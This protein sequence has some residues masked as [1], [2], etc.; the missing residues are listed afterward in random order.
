MSVSHRESE[1]RPGPAL[2]ISRTSQVVALIRAEL[3]RP[4]TVE[5][6]PDAQRKLCAGMEPTRGVRLRSAI[7]ARTRFFDERVL[8]EISAGLCQV[9]I[10]GAGYDDRALRFRTAGV[11]FFELDH[12]STQSDK[13][14]RLKRIEADV[15][16]LR[17]IPVDF[18]SDPVADLLRAQGLHPEEPSLFICEGLLVY[19]DLQACL[20]LLVALRSLAAPSSVLATSFT[21]IREGEVAE[22]AIA[23]AN[24]RR[25]S[26]WTEPWRTVLAPD[27]CVA[28][29]AQAGWKVELGHG[30][31]EAGRGESLGHMLLLTAR[32]C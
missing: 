15:R 6:D 21:T 32:P 24:A 2:D 23:K 9:V 29:L 28:L 3:N 7:V 22:S 16:G 31:R 10:C 8:S 11:Q 26:G 12:P 27:A 17:L 4:F 13:A 20:R 1:S 19:L 14:L 25:R 18:R 5:G 30:P